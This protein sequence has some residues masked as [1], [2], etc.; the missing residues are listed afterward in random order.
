MG[1]KEVNID[2]T[3]LQDLEVICEVHMTPEDGIIITGVT[4]DMVR[5]EYKAFR[6]NAL[7]AGLLKEIT[8]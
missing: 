1:I 6:E 3:K 2:F 4:K 7:E 5:V 8:G